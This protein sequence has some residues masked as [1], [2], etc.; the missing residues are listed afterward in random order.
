MSTQN[1]WSWKV[2]GGADSTFASGSFVDPEG[3]TI[4]LLKRRECLVRIFHPSRE[5]AGP[6]LPPDRRDRASYTLDA[7]WTD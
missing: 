7:D 6:G 3:N 5:R 2:R 1:G 4:Q